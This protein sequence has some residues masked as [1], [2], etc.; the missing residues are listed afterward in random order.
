MTP[1]D[2]KPSLPDDKAFPTLFSRIADD[3]R[4][5]ARTETALQLLRNGLQTDEIMNARF[6][7]V[8]F[9]L[10]RN[11]DDAWKSLVR[12]DFPTW[13]ENEAFDKIRGR[14]PYLDGPSALSR[15]IRI[16]DELRHKAT[17][18]TVILL[19]EKADA[20]GAEMR[21]IAESFAYL[22]TRVV[23]V[24]R[25]APPPEEALPTATREARELVRN[26]L[27]GALDQVRAAYTAHVRQM[28]EREFQ[29]IDSKLSVKEDARKLRST[30]LEVFDAAFSMDYHGHELVV[31]R[32]P[33][34]TER[35]D[36]LAN[37]HVQLVFTRFLMKNVEKLAAVVELKAGDPPAIVL[38][39]AEVNGSVLETSVSFRF[40][41]QSSFEVRNSVVWQSSSLGHYY[42]RF[43][44]TFHDVLLADGT[45]L[46]H[47]SEADMKKVFV[48][49]VTAP[50]DDMPTTAGPSG[51]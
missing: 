12:Q 1:S 9:D 36:A 39:Q 43:P 41:D 47:P 30:S 27:S 19:M 35:L 26:A 50:E 15:F 29:M 44:T 11:I 8:A 24:T 25:Q 37:R 20:F 34:A 28:F 51:P 49:P 38:N 14:F 4:H 18:P 6:K 40:K 2:L 42:A 5:R 22:K 32:R 33:D 48:E 46:T 16:V 3:P 45:R 21:P 13:G 7:E 31:T 10:M 17:D 23:K